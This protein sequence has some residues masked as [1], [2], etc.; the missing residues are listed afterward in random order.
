ML[1]CFVLLFGL[2]V[3]MWWISSYLAELWPSKPVIAVLATFAVSGKDASLE[4]I[5]IQ[6]VCRAS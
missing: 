3:K 6:V 4:Q 2:I 1:F 5:R